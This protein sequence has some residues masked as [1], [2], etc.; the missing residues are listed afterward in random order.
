MSCEIRL[1]LDGDLGMMGARSGPLDAARMAVPAGGAM[2]IGWPLIWWA[3]LTIDRSMWVGHAL[4]VSSLIHM[5][6]VLDLPM[7]WPDEL[8]G[9][10]NLDLG[11]RTSC[12]VTGEGALLLPHGRSPDA[13]SMKTE[14]CHGLD[15]L[16]VVDVDEVLRILEEVGAAV[17][18][19]GSDL[20]IRARRRWVPWV[21]RG[22]DGAPDFGAPVVFRIPVW[23]GYDLYLCPVTVTSPSAGVQ[24]SFW[25]RG[26]T[27][28]LEQLLG[29]RRYRVPIKALHFMR[30]CASCLSFGSVPLWR[31]PTMGSFLDDALWVDSVTNKVSWCSIEGCALSSMMM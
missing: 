14:C 7:G 16:Q 18:L 9:Y 24:G 15:G 20:P 31:Y 11:G 2:E 26:V 23:D 5:E 6:V 13:G 30:A 19:P 22:E 27:V 28:G 8:L 3:V 17:L 12:W 10:K 21:A 25:R 29:V 1:G 4:L